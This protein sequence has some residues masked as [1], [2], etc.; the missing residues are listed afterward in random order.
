MNKF[1]YLQ[2]KNLAEAS[3]FLGDDW[4]KQ[5][6]LAGGTDLVGLMKDNVEKPEKVVNLKSV[7]DLDR[8]SY[9][10]GQG[11]RIGA[12]VTITELM[13][14]PVIKEKF[15]VINQAAQKIASPQLR[16]V[17]TVGG[18]LCQRPRCWYYRGDFDCL[19]KGGDV[20][21]AVDG[22]NKYHC[23]VGGGPCFIVHQSDLAVALLVLDAVVTMFDGEN[24]IKLPLKDFFVLPDKNVERENILE[25][26]QIVTGIYVPEPTKNTVSGYIKFME[27]STWDFAIVSV[28]AVLE[29]TNGVI[30]QGKIALGGVAPKPWT[31]KNFNSNLKGFKLTEENINRVASQALSDAEPMKENGFKIKLA[32]NLIKKLIKNLSDHG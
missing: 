32:Q 29:R 5:L 6:L 13:K 15:T 4:K 1:E 27:R 16:N 8:I 19:R 31:D 11:L 25:P 20:C 28:A 24:Q 30:K 23:V 14:H 17:G 7:T 12:L 22:S 21:F 3:V 9:Q 10:P 18:N 26:N 2:P